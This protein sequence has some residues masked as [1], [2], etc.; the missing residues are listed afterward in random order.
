MQ[1]PEAVEPRPRPPLRV[2]L[3]VAL[4]LVRRRV[5]PFLAAR[6]LLAVAWAVLAGAA[7]AQGERMVSFGDLQQ[8]LADGYVHHVVVSRGLGPDEHGYMPQQI[9]WQRGPVTFRA[10]VVER[11]PGKSGVRVRRATGGDLPVFAEDVAGRLVRHHPDLLV[12]RGPYRDPGSRIKGWAMPSWTASSL[13]LLLVLTMGLLAVGREPRWATRWA[14][15]WLL[16]FVPPLGVPAFLALGTPRAPRDPAARE[17]R[18]TGFPALVLALVLPGLW[19]LL[20][21]VA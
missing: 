8:L 14:W 19:T 17:R 20:V 21:S 13:L 15:F 1:T 6:V 11:S 2:V 9:R 7:V 10:Q 3:R 16:A 4:R 18:V 12:E 5:D